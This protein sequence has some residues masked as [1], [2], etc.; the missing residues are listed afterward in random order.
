MCM[1]QES[2]DSQCSSGHKE[3]QQQSQWPT[4]IPVFMYTLMLDGVEPNEYL[5]FRLNGLT[6]MEVLQGQDSTVI[7]NAD[8]SE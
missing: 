6:R 7:R 3:I 1:P 2:L 8:F 4:V 5:Q